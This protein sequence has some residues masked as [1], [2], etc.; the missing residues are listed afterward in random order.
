M[1]RKT[2][3]AH[4]HDIAIVGRV[5]S[6]GQCAECQRIHSRDYKTRN[7]ALVIERARLDRELNRSIFGVARPP[8]VAHA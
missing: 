8:K 6:N 5:R 4:G 2:H 3:C 1:P 7:H